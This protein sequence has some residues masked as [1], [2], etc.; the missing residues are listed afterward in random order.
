M[1]KIAQNKTNSVI[2][3]FFVYS[4]IW[5]G[6]YLFVGNPI[7]RYSEKIKS[8]FR[9][10]TGQLKE[11]YDLV[12]AVPNQGIAMED[13]EKKTRELKDK[14]AIKGQ[15]SRVIRDITNKARESG[16]DI[17]S[18]TPRED[19]K[20]DPERLPMGVTKVY[21]ELVVTAS[22]QKVEKYMK[23][24][25]EMPIILIVESV[26]LEKN[27]SADKKNELAADLILSTFTI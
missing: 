23:A 13:I 19:M 12:K 10:K 15:I 5:I 7:F 25:S 8:E 20:S 21:I 26:S 9:A 17:V 24:L 6:L 16:V 11:S 2:L 14:T 18:V 3:S 27:E 22:Y 1:F 4:A